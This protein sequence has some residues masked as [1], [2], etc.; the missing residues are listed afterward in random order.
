MNYQF[1]LN[2]YS[3]KK[4][5]IW[6]ECLYYDVETAPWNE[7]FRG[8]DDTKYLD[9]QTVGITSFCVM[10]PK[11]IMTE[12]RI[13]LCKNLAYTREVN[14]DDTTFLAIYYYNEVRALTKKILLHVLDII[15]GGLKKKTFLCGFN[16]ESF[17]DI[18]IGARLKEDISCWHYHLSDGKETKLYTADL[19]Y[20]C[21][22][23]GF[24]KLADVGEYMKIPK[25]KQWNSLEEFLDYNIRDVMILPAFVKMLNEHGLY[26]LR[27]ATAARRLVSQEM[28]QKLNMNR[29]F[30]DQ[31]I[32]DSIPLFGGRTEPYYAIGEN[33]YYLDVNSLYPYTMVNFLFPKPTVWKSYK[34]NGK[35]I[36]DGQIIHVKTS[37]NASRR[38]E[39]QEFLDECGQYILYLAETFKCITPQMLKEVFEDKSPWFGVLFVKLH[40]IRP[41]WKEY[42]KQLL[43]Y[44]PFP[45]KKDGYTLFSFDPD[46]IY[47]VQ[48]YE[49]MWLSFFDY[50]IL[51]HIE[52]TR[53]RF[54]LADKIVERYE[55]RKKLKQNKDSAEKAIKILLNTGYGIYATRNHYKRRIT[56]QNEYEKYYSYWI[57]AG[58]PDEFEIYDDDYKTVKVRGDKIDVY[59]AD[60]KRRYADNTVPIWAIA[61]TSHARFSLYCYMLNGILTPP[62]IDE[63]YRIFYVDTDSIFCPEKLYKLLDAGGVVGAELGQLELEDN[64]PLAYFLAPKT[65]ILVPKDGK[66]LKKFKGTGTLFTKTIVAQSLKTDFTVYTRETLRPEQPQKRRLEEDYSFTATPSPEP[67]TKTLKE[68]YE[69]CKKKYE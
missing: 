16:N 65:Y 7:N 42:E 11:H 5:L 69:E 62:E 43:H 37:C 9:I 33:L 44:F 38:E 10:V 60:P 25:I 8:S 50:T 40:G 58:R 13:R 35:E 57:A 49:L 22:A 39:I 45:R 56:E 26:A 29:I 55:L 28:H 67:G 2:D 52:Y 61:T 1:R 12:K 14:M 17:D 6:N 48:F 47:C 31:Q 27:P 18:I 41:E 53:D 24:S 15:A 54:P 34:K 66:P 23:Y 36:T 30:S 68:L 3:K 21:K 63:R 4:E 59:I 64:V 32:S 19:Y 20:W 51:E 46:D